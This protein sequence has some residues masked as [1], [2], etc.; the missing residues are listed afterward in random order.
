MAA[1]A[2]DAILEPF[3]AETFDLPVS[4]TTRFNSYW[5]AATV[6][7]LLISTYLW[8]KRPPER[9]AKIANW[10]LGAMALSSVSVLTNALRL[11]RIAPAMYEPPKT[12]TPLTQ[13]Q[14]Q[15]AE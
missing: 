13:A 10:G 11:R 8:R 5:Q 14:T 12:E 4:R 1:W 15:P 7:T 2:Q 6:V 3:G 9:Q